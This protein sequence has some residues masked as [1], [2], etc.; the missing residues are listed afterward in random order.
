MKSGI[1]PKVLKGS[2]CC[3]ASK[4]LPTRL[5]TRSL[6]LNR[7]SLIIKAVAAPEKPTAEEVPFTAWDT[8]V[9][10]IAKR[11]DLKTIMILGAGP[12]VI[13]QVRRLFLAGLILPLPCLTLWCYPT[14]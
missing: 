1:H 6:K 8:A 9:Q 7:S 14:H 4:G 12:I 13:G 11:D 2:K 10:R 3:N 5:P